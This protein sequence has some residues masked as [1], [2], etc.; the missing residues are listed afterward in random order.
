MHVEHVYFTPT[1]NG[2]LCARESHRIDGR[3]I[4]PNFKTSTSVSRME[5]NGVVIIRQPIFLEISLA[6]PISAPLSV[7]VGQPCHR[8]GSNTDK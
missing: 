8:C 1:L 3:K 7:R 6:R 2:T 5:V 4:R